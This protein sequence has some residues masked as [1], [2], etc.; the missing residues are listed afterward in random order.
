MG[1]RAKHRRRVLSAAKAE[2]PDRRLARVLRAR[3]SDEPAPVVRGD[4]PSVMPRP[5]KQKRRR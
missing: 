4:S 2:R 3:A 5:R 1:A